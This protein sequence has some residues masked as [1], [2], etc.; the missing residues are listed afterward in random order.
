MSLKAGDKV[1]LPSFGG[2]PVKFGDEVNIP[3]LFLVLLTYS[4]GL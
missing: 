3:F 2:T 4:L 1:I